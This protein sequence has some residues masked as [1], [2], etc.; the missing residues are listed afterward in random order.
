CGGLVVRSRPGG[1]RVA[2]SRP[3]ST[4]DPPYMGPAA[5]Q[6]VRSGQTSSRWCGA[7]VWRG[8]ASSGAVLV[9]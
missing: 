9:I 8:G 5:R 2:G 7:A 3:D 6:I 4:E 1:Q